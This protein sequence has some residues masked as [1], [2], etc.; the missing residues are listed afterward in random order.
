MVLRLTDLEASRKPRKPEDLASKLS[1]QLELAG[2]DCFARE[3]LFHPTR[4]WRIDIAWPGMKLAVEC[5]GVGPKGQPGRHQLT[6]HLHDNCEKHSALGAMG[7]RLLRFTGKQIRSGHALKWI[8]AAMFS[9][10]PGA[11]FAA[12]WDAMTRRRRTRRRG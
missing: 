6:Q 2:F 12:P 4:K 7:W 10:D 5:E 8:E 1:A 3:Y 9:P 11:A